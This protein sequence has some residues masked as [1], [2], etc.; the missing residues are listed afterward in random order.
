MIAIVIGTRA[1]LIKTF[2]VMLELD[3][4]KISF[5]FVHTGQ[6]SLG[7]LCEKFSVRKPDFILSKEPSESTK[8]YTKVAK[9]MFWNLWMVIKLWLTLFKIKDLRYVIYH[10]DTMTTASIA[11]ASSR[12]FNPFKKYK[13]VHL[14]AG[15]RSGSLKEPFPE[16]ISRKIA[17]RFS[18]ILL[19]VSDRSEKNIRKEKLRG[20]VVK[21]GNTV[22]D[23]VE[24]AYR[25]ALKKKTKPLSKGKFALI[26]IHRHENIK[27]RDRLTKIV[28]ILSHVR[29]LSFFSLHDN[30]KKKLIDF[31]LY[32]KLKRNPN[33][34]LIDPL[35]YV[36]YSFQMKNCEFMITDGG[37][38]QEESLVFGKPCVILRKF[39]ERQ[40]GLDTGINFLTGLDVEKS[41]KIIEKIENGGILV[42]KFEN[43]YGRKGVSK[44]IVERLVGQ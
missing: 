27:T 32:D 5:V 13:S 30:T 20:L 25:L 41:V 2:P 11:I 34:K 36:E 19:A 9:A 3:K 28:E 21:V 37:S 4:R 26:S 16:E 31:G 14:E 15:L 38:I 22:V 12:L 7:G 44:K 8:F 6:H 40:E 33:I 23:S 24:I 10:G 1:E 42:R 35:D 18:D 17:D 39:T 29:T 43:P